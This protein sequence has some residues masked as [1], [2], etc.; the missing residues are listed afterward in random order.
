MT[1]LGGIEAGGT[2]FVCA[3]GTHPG[4]L[5]AVEL[6]T[7]TPH[8]TIQRVVAFFQSR[9]P[10]EAIGIGSFGPIDPNPKS[11]TFGFVTSTP[12]LDWR[13]FDFAGAIREALHVPVA[14]DTDVNAAALA[15]HKWGAAQGLD[16]FLYV[17]VGTGVGGGA[18]ANGGLLHGKMHPEMG[19]IR[20][21]HDLQLDPFPGNCPYHGDC[22]E[23]L[24]SAP[25]IEARWGEPAHS[26]RASH[27]A[28]PLVAHY[29]AL[30]LANWICTLSP[31]KIIL[32]GGVMQRQE[33][34]APM[35]LEVAKLL[36]GYV[37]APDI[38]PPQLGARAGV[39]GAI[40][41][42]EAILAPPS[43]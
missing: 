37:T 31:E 39:L 17:T 28:W 1:R 24:V 43:G 21:P 42:A 2:K 33:L 29:L 23:G 41:L 20:V 9:P 30:G 38:V 11:P 6:P 27:P 10:L 15:E 32:G 22:L 36:N 25:A 40:A 19:H 14:F 7:T 35:R 34:F 3:V 13:N 8:E 26:L 4:D 18:M 16:A 12:K 5:D